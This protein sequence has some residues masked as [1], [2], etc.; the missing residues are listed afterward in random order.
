M[1]GDP[2]GKHAVGRVIAR[3]FIGEPG[4]YERTPNR[5][6]FS[7]EPKGRTTCRWFATQA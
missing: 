7:L 3:P 1:R 4:N 2:T 5:H 6:D